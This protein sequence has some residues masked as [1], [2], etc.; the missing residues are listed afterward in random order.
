MKFFGLF[1]L[2]ILLISVGFVSADPVWIAF[3]GFN[4]DCS[5]LFGG[6]EVQNGY[7]GCFNS[8]P[9]ITEE[10]YFEVIRMKTA[11][12]IASCCAAGASSAGANEE[13]IES[14]RK[15]GEHVG[16]AFQ[17]R[18]DLFDFEKENKTDLPKISIR[19][20]QDEQ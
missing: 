9:D 16:I 4:K 17:I 14:M 3:C 18:D 12:L 5:G 11:S 13:Q 15:F 2:G 8:E 6:A 7:M 1:V 20:K 10:V 19:S